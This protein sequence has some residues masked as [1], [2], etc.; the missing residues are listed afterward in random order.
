MENRKDIRSI[1][2]KSLQDWLANIGEKPFRA[3]QIEEWLWKKSAA[4]FTEMAN[5]PLSLRDKLESEFSLPVMKIADMQRSSD[6][7]IKMAFRL[8]DGFTV[9]GV[10]IPSGERMTACISS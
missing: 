7:T 1:T 5:L 2:R 8:H 10:L 3:A 4:S 6:G 9:E